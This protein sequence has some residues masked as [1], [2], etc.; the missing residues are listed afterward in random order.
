M[1]KY[2]FKLNGAGQPTLL[3]CSV[4]GCKELLAQM[5]IEAEKA[6][7]VNVEPY[8]LSRAIQKIGALRAVIKMLDE[9]PAL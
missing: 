2:E 1:S 6:K 9:L 3:Q 7:P 8:V 5:L 4:I